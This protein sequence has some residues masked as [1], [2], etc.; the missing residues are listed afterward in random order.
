MLA[1]CFI[2]FLLN[3]FFAFF[4]SNKLLWF[5]YPVYTIL[6]FVFFFYILIVELTNKSIKRFFFISSI[7]F[8]LGIIIFYSN[9]KIQR[10]DSLPIAFETILIYI[11]I[12][13]YL[14]DKFNSVEGQNLQ[15]RLH[16]WF[17]IGILFY[18]SGT[19]FFNILANHLNPK[20]VAQY[21]H[22]SFF[23]DI[24]KNLIFA[25]SIFIFANNSKKKIT[26]KQ[27]PNLDFTL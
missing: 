14:K 7:L 3:Y 16:F 17:V 9:E 6:E 13:L 19:F 11:F 5:Y 2:F 4:E 1:Y 24:I 20:Q 10:L 25:S 18:L 21:W 27:V 22:Y 15:K 26:S 12:F 8:I 23:A